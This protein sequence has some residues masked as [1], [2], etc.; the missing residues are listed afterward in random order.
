MAGKFLNIIKHFFFLLS[1]SELIIAGDKN[2]DVCMW[3]L[4][5]KLFL[6]NSGDFSASI[7][8]AINKIQLFS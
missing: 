3:L 6:L 4:S 2:N 1:L 7:R 8:C 5:Y